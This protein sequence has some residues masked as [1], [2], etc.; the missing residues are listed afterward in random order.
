[1]CQNLVEVADC[2][3][4]NTPLH[5]PVF[6]QDGNWHAL[7]GMA[8]QSCSTALYLLY[9]DYWVSGFLLLH[10]CLGLDPECTAGLPVEHVVP[11]TSHCN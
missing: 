8:V 3:V 1:M 4:L 9:L 11:V 2:I 6:L 7:G 10:L 5:A